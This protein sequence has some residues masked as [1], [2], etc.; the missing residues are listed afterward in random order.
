[1]YIAIQNCYNNIK[2]FYEILKSEQQLYLVLCEFNNDQC[3]RF[4]DFDL[5]YICFPRNALEVDYEKD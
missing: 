4:V 3:N 5:I 2:G 1:L